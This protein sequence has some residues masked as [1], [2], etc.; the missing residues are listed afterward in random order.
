MVHEETTQSPVLF[1]PVDR[2]LSKEQ[3]RNLSMIWGSSWPVLE[4]IHIHHAKID[5]MV[6]QDQGTSLFDYNVDAGQIVLLLF[7]GT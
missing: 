1:F 5:C 2:D 4:F 6:T 7:P 3:H